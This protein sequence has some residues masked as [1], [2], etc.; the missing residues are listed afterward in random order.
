[1]KHTQ[2]LVNEH[3]GIL[4]MLRIMDRICD[5]IEAERIGPG[6]HEEF[7][8]LLKSLKGAYLS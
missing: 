7:H 2:Q 4:L 3:D 8:E 1:M 5:R 6:R